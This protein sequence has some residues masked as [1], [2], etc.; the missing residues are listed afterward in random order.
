MIG[1]IKPEDV[2]S[3]KPMPASVLS[4]ARVATDPDSSLAE[5]TRIIELDEALTANIL[6]MANSAWSSSQKKI[7]TVRAA[8]IRMGSGKI[9]RMAVGRSIGPAMESGLPGYAL[10]E[11]ELWRHSVAAA[12]AAEHMGAHAKADI[13]AAAFTAAL[14]HDIGKLLLSRHINAETISR[15]LEM[16]ESKKVS[17]VEAERE[18][19]GAD[20]AQVG[21]AIARQW[22][23]PE[24]LVRA[25]ELHHD[26]D[27]E[28]DSLRDA[29]HVANTVAKLVGVGLGSEQ[30]YLKVSDAAPQRLGMSPAGLE[31]LCA[32]VQLELDQAETLFMGKENGD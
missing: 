24:P 19:V 21:G 15:I 16:A 7:D 26:P 27:Q 29:V 12:L 11:H 9:L 20:H 14:L 8:V 28:P 6:K 10:G 2:E 32:R 17:Y 13:P 22:K 23:F 31:A 4:L 18:V 30:M 3:L 25:I 5:I 1:P